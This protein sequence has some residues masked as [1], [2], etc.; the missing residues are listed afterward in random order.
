VLVT[1]HDDKPV[2]KVIDFGIAKAT[3]GPLT[4]K[5]LFTGFAQLIGSP[6]Y[7][8]PEQAA[9]SAID[10]DTRSDI[11]SLGVLLYEL[12]TGTT[13]F[14]KSRLQKA[15]FDDVRRIIQEEEPPRPSARISTLR[16]AETARAT[17]Q[18]N[19]VGHSPTPVYLGEL[20]W[21]VM[22]A[23]EKD[24]NRRYESAGALARDIERHLCDEP[25]Q[26]CPPSSWY[27]FRKFARR[28][29]PAM[30]A[31]A[32]M[33]LAVL[34]SLAAL[35]TSTLRIARQQI[36]TTAA[37]D[38]ETVAKDELAQNLARERISGA[39]HALSTDDLGHAV[40]LLDAC[41][42]DLRD[43][44]WR[45]LMRLCR[46]QPLIVSDD[47]EVNG[48]AFS[49]DGERIA[50]AGGDGSIK[51]WNSRMGDMVQSFPAHANS[52]V[53]VTF[54]PDGNQLASV[55]ADR[56][57]RVWD[58]TTGDELFAAPCD[59]VRKNGSAYTVAFS[60]DGRRL[61][62]ASEGAVRIW[63]WPDHRLLHS[64]P[65]HGFHSIPVA[66]SRDGRRLATFAGERG[67]LHLWD[68]ETGQLLGT[69]LAHRGPVTGLA[70]S[71]DGKWLASASY[72]KGVK[73]SDSTTGALL[74]TVDSHTNVECVAIS[75]DAKLVAS[76]GEDETVRIWSTTTDREVLALSGHTGRCCCVAFS[77]DGL[78][79]ASASTDRTI[80]VWDATP[81]QGN[82]HQEFLNFTRHDD[83]IRTLAV[84]PDES[85][86]VASAGSDGTVKVWDMQTGRVSAEF[87]AHSMV[88][89][90]LAWHPDAE[91]IAAAG[92]GDGRQTVKVWNVRTEQKDIELPDKRLGPYF[93]AA[94]SCDGRYLVTGHANGAVEVW[95]ARTGRPLNTLG[96]HGGA[97]RGLVCSTDGKHLASSSEGEVKLWDATRLDEAQ[98]EPLTLP[99]RVPG[100]SMNVGFSQDGRRL[101]TAGEKNT[102]IIWDVETGAELLTLWGEH[103]GEVYAVAFSP[104]DD[105]R[106][107]ATAGE[108]SA[109]KVWDSHSGKLIHSFRG[110]TG[111][112]SSLA[113]S[114]DG[115]RLISGSRDKTVKV[116]AMLSWGD[117]ERKP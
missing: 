29:K 43:W 35:A 27:R 44:E 100:D 1:L 86:R 4:D 17:S 15:A 45:Y 117:S 95:D 50:S 54:H 66:F 22:K 6:L 98:E 61:A 64:L 53:A 51:I 75:P 33:G 2:V 47:T 62:A 46:V 19:F 31:A 16:N 59:I 5:T 65:P 28:N 7:M 48:L 41:P 81:L 96:T 94:F 21:I 93:D 83:E 40:K 106:L 34:L 103:S 25:V 20:D 89:F 105:G 111:L 114:R 63:D 92:S 88:V 37:L 12:L 108:D 113:F 112:V 49:P 85:Q 116:W 104:L 90:G 32:V 10:V 68:A 91:R 13:P 110:H 115:H 9:L 102:V 57:V 14:E 76:G 109:V 74:H 30:A 26:A 71:P 55:G 82:E 24:R 39:L 69:I 11:Y 18:R 8:S 87:R 70:F 79:L 23:L 80:R 77:P 101:A 36:V 67:L 60:H 3:S 99:A 72:A 78:R 97:V 56:L 58:L 42:P 52:V 38:A 73:L 84:S 107:I